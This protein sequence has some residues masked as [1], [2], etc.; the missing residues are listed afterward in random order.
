MSKYYCL[1]AGLPDITIDDNKLSYTVKEFRAEL[2]ETLSNNDKKLI[3]LFYLQFDHKNLLAMLTK[4]E[5]KFD[6]R[7]LY[8]SEQLE[9]IIALVKEN[10]TPSDKKYP[11][12]FYVF[13]AAYLQDKPLIDNMSWEDQLNSLYYEYAGNSSNRFVS[14]WFKLNLNL[15]N[16]LTA[17]IC[18]KYNREVGNAIIGK[19]EISETI[20]QS[21]QRD[22]G[23][24][25]MVDYLDTILRISE[26]NNLY[27]RERKLDQF[28]W[29][30][31]DEYSFFHY[32]TIERI[33]A[34][35]IKLDILERWVSMTPENGRAIF[36]E[37]IDS[38]KKGI[39]IPSDF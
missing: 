15:N 11:S 17:I 20:R 7:G 23:L 28:R 12:Y 37:M 8:T 29:N 35:L 39:E 22:M 9:E 19:S 21:G 33:F 38:L 6:N 2:S 27:E 10:E 1:I 36:K 34:Y 5:V 4:Q 24:T 26:E 13:I 14:D 3:D 16:M 25:G 31:L 18:R 32:F 30:W